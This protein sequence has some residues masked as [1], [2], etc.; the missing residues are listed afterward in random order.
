MGSIKIL[1]EE[2]RADRKLEKLHPHLQ[3]GVMNILDM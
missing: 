3:I 2:N 1:A